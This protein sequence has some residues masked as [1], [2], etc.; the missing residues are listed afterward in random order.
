MSGEAAKK[1]L[2]PIANGSE[3]IESVCIIDTLRRAGAEVTGAR[4]T[5][6]LGAGATN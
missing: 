6:T 5:A 4:T 3:E 1:V 2:V